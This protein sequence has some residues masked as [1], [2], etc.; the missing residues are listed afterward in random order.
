MAQIPSAAHKRR[1]LPLK[2]KHQ[3][4]PGDLCFDCWVSK[5]KKD[6]MWNMFAALT[7]AAPSS[8]Q[9]KRRESIASASTGLKGST[10]VLDICSK[11]LE[12][13]RRESITDQDKSHGLSESGRTSSNTDLNTNSPRPAAVEKQVLSRPKILPTLGAVMSMKGPPEIT[14]ISPRC[15]PSSGGT[16]IIIRGCN[17]GRSQDDFLGVF[18]C[19]CESLDTLEYH[20][21]AKVVCVTKPWNGTK[22]NPGPVVLVTKSGGRVSRLFSSNIKVIQSE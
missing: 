6:K 10:S 4:T 1:W 17:L 3:Q 12:E 7:T 13:D 5:F 15:G 22:P 21:P 18:V 8:P 2:R 20:S 19:S 16:K 9:E 11:S 14:G